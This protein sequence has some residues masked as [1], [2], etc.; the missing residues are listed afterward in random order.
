MISEGL[1]KVAVHKGRDAWG[2]SKSSKGTLQFPLVVDVLEA[3]SED[4]E[5]IEKQDEKG[6]P[7]DPPQRTIFMYVST[8]T[9]ER[10]LRELQQIGYPHK[11]L[12][13]QALSVGNDQSF[14]FGGIEFTAQCKHEEYKGKPKERWQVYR[15]KGVAMTDED[16]SQ[17]ESTFGNEPAKDG[18]NF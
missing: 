12:I 8:Q 14:D 9:W 4:A 5:E 16:L 17:F 6:K 11:K 1:Y 13:P 2:L 18:G 15:P 3:A 10:T 7:L